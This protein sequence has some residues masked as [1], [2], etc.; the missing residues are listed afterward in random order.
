MVAQAYFIMAIEAWIFTPP[1]IICQENNRSSFTG[2]Y[3]AV[4]FDPGSHLLNLPFLPSVTGNLQ[5][6]AEGDG[7]LTFSFSISYPSKHKHRVS[8]AER[9]ITASQPLATIAEPLEDF[10]NGNYYRLHLLI[11]HQNGPSP[12]QSQVNLHPV[13]FLN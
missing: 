1:V 13:L 2:N 3:L 12:S 11:R 4:I 7:K 6:G 9:L 8:F 5:V 10:P